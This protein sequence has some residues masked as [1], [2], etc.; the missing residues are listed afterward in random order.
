MR[1]WLTALVV[2]FE[3]DTEARAGSKL[4]VAI[5]DA[6]VRIATFMRGYAC[7]GIAGGRRP[8]LRLGRPC[9]R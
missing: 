3:P 8:A 4:K 9:G 1:D 6:E 2:F 5:Y 7:V